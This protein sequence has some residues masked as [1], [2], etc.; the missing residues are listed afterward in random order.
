MLLKKVLSL[1][2]ATIVAAYGA[3]VYAEGDVMTSGV[4]VNTSM[5]AQDASGVELISQS[6]DPEDMEG[7]GAAA[8]Q[9][10]TDSSGYGSQPNGS[11][12]SEKAETHR[13]DFSPDWLPGCVGPVSFCD[14]YFGN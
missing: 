7:Q 13:A 8:S 10:K 11:M 14:I 1:S 4:D 3:Q 9:E 5:V 6:A 12:H 2:I